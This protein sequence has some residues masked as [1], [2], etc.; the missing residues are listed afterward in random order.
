MLFARLWNSPTVNTWAAFGIR[1]LNVVLVLP[2]ALRHFTDAETALWS[3]FSAM[4]I[5]QPLA[6]FGFQ[7]TFVRLTA[8]AFGGAISLDAAT[9]DEQD[10]TPGLPNWALI[11]R[12]AGATR[13][14]YRALSWVLLALCMGVGSPLLWRRIDELGHTPARLAQMA[15]DAVSLGDFSLAERLTLQAGRMTTPAEA[16]IAWGI[17]VIVTVTTFR[18]NGAVAYL[19]GCGQVALVRR[20]EALFGFG[21]LLTG[22]MILWWRGSLFGLILMNQAWL[23]LGVARN[24]WLARRVHEGQLR[25]Y[26]RPNRD[27]EILRIAWPNAW[28]AGLG[29]WAGQGAVQMG[30]LIFAQQRNSAAVASYLIGLRLVQ[31]IGIVAGGAITG[32]LPRLSVLWAQGNQRAFEAE[33]RRGTA[34]A[35]WACALPLG[36]LAWLGPWFLK[37]GLHSAVPFVARSTW[38][39]L[40]LGTFF[41]RYGASHLALETSGN[42]VR[43]HISSAVCAA[44]FGVV[45]AAMF[46]VLGVDALPLGVLVGSVGFLAWFG[47][48]GSAESLGLRWPDFDLK[49]AA[50]PAAVLGGSLAARWWMGS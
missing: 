40:A 22:A 49:T 24:Q 37:S 3:V 48:W 45:A 25:R 31:T 41:E 27:A 17:I 43:W 38:T 7:G 34:L 50:V 8:Y 29:S 14:L 42:R 44:I 4:L 21:A 26:P 33:A 47:R 32:R 5:F 11:R 46:P 19:A 36:A 30:G 28:R 18:G 10:Q 13:W 35:L 23:L 15:A 16:W 9:I 39:L 20:W 6:D 12:I 1:T 2:L